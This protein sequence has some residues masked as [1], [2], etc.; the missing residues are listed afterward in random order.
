MRIDEYAK[1][2]FTPESAPDPRTLI[3]WINN[4][5]LPG[6]QM[7]TFYYVDIDA[8]Q[9]QTGNKLADQIL[10]RIG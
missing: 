7:G 5:V 10:E 8:E 1:K 9:K 4:K 3:K 2:R 6:K